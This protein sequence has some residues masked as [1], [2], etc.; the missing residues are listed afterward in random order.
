VTHI[1]SSLDYPA[2][3]EDASEVLRTLVFSE[4]EVPAG[5][6]GTWYSCRILPYRAVN[7]A[8][9][10]VVITFTEITRAK[11]LESELRTKASRRKSG[12][13]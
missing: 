1:V 13:Q 7:N 3:V 2:L 4:R 5:G 10:G 8:I 9:G 12:A 6:G 11:H